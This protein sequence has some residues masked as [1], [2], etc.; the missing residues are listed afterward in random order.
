MTKNH[1]FIHDVPSDFHAIEWYSSLRPG[2]KRKVDSIIYWLK[3]REYSLTPKQLSSLAKINQSTAR[4]YLV[5]MERN[6]LVYANPRG[7]YQVAKVA[8]GISGDIRVQNITIRLNGFKIRRERHL[9][10]GHKRELSI[11]MSSGKSSGNTTIRIGCPSGIGYVE[12]LILEHL[13]K[14]E[15]SSDG[16]SI[17]DREWNSSIVTSFEI[18]NDYIGVSISGN[19]SITVQTARG[20]LEKIYSKKYGTRHEVRITGKI[21]TSLIEKILSRGAMFYP[22]SKELEEQKKLLD[23]A[24]RSVSMLSKEISDLREWIWNKLSKIGNPGGRNL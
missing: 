15:I 1:D 12:W 13:I 21:E 16:A 5:E 3:K 6:G 9:E 8:H 23:A 24:N 17:G 7:Y 19:K 4:N 10:F 2:K 14:S 18:F 11:T 22:I 20:I